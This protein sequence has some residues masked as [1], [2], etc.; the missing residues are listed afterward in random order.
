MLQGPDEHRQG[1]DSPRHKIKAHAQVIGCGNSGERIDPDDDQGPPE[2]AVGREGGGAEEVVLFE[3]HQPCDD[4]CAAS[5]GKAHRDDDDRKRHDASVVKIQ[6]KRCHA[7][8]EQT[9]RCRICNGSGVGSHL[10]LSG[11]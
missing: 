6:Q 8:A 4:L 2:E 5:E 7:E 11:M 9:E 1:E 10:F 3:L